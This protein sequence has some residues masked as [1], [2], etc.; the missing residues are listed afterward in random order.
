MTIKYTHRD[1]RSYYQELVENAL[2]YLADNK[3]DKCVSNIEA[4]SYL[5]YN[6]NY[7]YTD[8]VVEQIIKKISDLLLVT[9]NS[10]C[11]D[12]IIVWYDSFSW[13]NRGLTQQYI[14]ALSVLD[15]KK[16]VY[17]SE[18]GIDGRGNDIKTSLQGYGNCIDIVE[19]NGDIEQK[20][21]KLY[22]IILK[23]RPAKFLLH[24][25][26]WTIAPIVVLYSFPQIKLYQINIT[27]HAFWVGSKRVDYS[28]EFRK[29]GFTVSREKR[30]ID[31]NKL[32][33][34]PYYPWHTDTAFNGFPIDTQ[35]KVVLFSGGSI[36]KI[37]GE[38]NFFF[39]LIRDILF[40]NENAI[41][42]FAGEGNT[43]WLKKLIVENN[44]GNRFILLGTRTDICEVFKRCDI[45]IGTYPFPGG[46]M[47]QYAA[48]YKKP[49][50]AYKNFN[51][52]SVEDLICTK[53]YEPF[54]FSN[55]TDLINEA[56]KLI[57]DNN[58]RLERGEF[59]SSLV[60][61]Q[62]EFRKKFKSLV[63]EESHVDNK[64]YCDFPQIDYNAFNESYL[65]RLN[66]NVTS[67]ELERRLF[68]AFGINLFR[69]SIRKW[70][71]IYKV[72]PCIWHKI[73]RRCKI[74]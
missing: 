23:Y 68:R 54:S 21:R 71:I 6:Y 59:F 24:S 64:Q 49:I 26:P 11:D 15:N 9:D 51:T 14:D 43:E 69:G 67:R 72:F 34:L 35:G 74:I 41:F 2:Q 73:L 8:D 53:K 66:K 31:I 65:D 70:K 27:D 61:L 38:D 46:L 20:V 60:L 18:G 30:G 50:L 25:T 55:R 45:Y 57:S 48:L 13:D 7:I 37:V 42:L 40:A 63:I 10:V 33:F 5:Q 28:V 56:K 47:S 3:I 29:Y 4:S 62:P 16:F 22:R 32:I 44:L 17:V 36:Y 1:I 58:Y 39:F 52:D 19:I 12:N